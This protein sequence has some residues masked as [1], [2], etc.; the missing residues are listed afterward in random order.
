MAALGERDLLG[1]RDRLEM[2][3][4]VSQPGGD[5]AVTPN[6][7]VGVRFRA[8]PRLYHF[9]AKRAAAN[10]YHF[11]VPCPAFT[12]L[13]FDSYRRAT[14]HRNTPLFPLAERCRGALERGGVPKRPSSR[15]TNHS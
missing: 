7:R 4:F 9:S 3:L 11:R 14:T 2:R 15:E 12:I 8:A 6:H 10:F 13:P 5:L 1:E